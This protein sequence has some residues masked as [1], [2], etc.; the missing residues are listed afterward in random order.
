MDTSTNWTW[1]LRPGPHQA[2]P[3]NGFTVNMLTSSLLR[4]SLA[5]LVKGT[6]YAD[7]DTAG[8]V[9]D[10]SQIFYEQM[11]GTQGATTPQPNDPVKVTHMPGPEALFE[12]IAASI[13]SHMLSSSTARVSGSAYTTETY[14]RARWAWVILPVALVTLTAILLIATTALS[15]KRDMAAWKSSA[16]PALFRGL[17]EFSAIGPCQAEKIEIMERR[18]DALF[19]RQGWYRTAAGKEK[20]RCIDEVF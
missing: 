17:D 11:T 13:T 12:R 8:M 2:E 6:V 9:D 19:K 15:A 7:P 16:L 14:V 4:E 18:A 10:V 5:N 3:G 20:V 1:A